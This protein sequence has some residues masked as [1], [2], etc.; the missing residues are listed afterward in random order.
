MIY[1]NPAIHG[2]TELRKLFEL[3]QSL[4]R[5]VWDPKVIYLGPSEWAEEITMGVLRIAT[6]PPENEYAPDHKFRV[7]DKVRRCDGISGLA[8]QD[9]EV[10]INHAWVVKDND[11]KAL[12]SEGLPIEGVINVEMLERLAELVMVRWYAPDGGVI[13]TGW[14]SPEQLEVKP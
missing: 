12:Q 2:D 13:C 1:G 5:E 14:H 4:C 9:G 7:G 10:V 6:A 8:T 3:Y 11:F